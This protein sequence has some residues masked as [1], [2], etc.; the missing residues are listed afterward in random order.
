MLRPLARPGRGAPE[1]RTPTRFGLAVREWDGDWLDAI[2]T[3]DD[4]PPPLRT[5]VTVEK[6]KTIITRNNS[7]DVK[8]LWLL[9]ETD[10]DFA[11]C[12]DHSRWRG[13]TALRVHALQGAL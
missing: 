12:P 10:P 11:Q 7:P 6:P 3:V 13:S 9:Q 4:G 5:S 1:N 2:G 8:I